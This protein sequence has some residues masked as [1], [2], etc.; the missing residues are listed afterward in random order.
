MPASASL[1]RVAAGSMVWLREGKIDDNGGGRPC[2]M[3]DALP[4]LLSFACNPGTLSPLAGR[5]DSTTMRGAISQ[6][7]RHS[8]T[9]CGSIWPARGFAAADIA[10]LGED[11]AFLKYGS[12]FPQ[13][14]TYNAGLAMLP[15]TRVRLL[16]FL[17]W[18]EAGMG[19]RPSIRFAEGG[20]APV[21]KA[22]RRATSP[23]PCTH[24]LHA[25]ADGT[26]PLRIV[27][28]SARTGEHAVQR[29]AHRDRDRP[30][31]GDCHGGRLDRRRQPVR[32][33][34]D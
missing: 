18:A 7:L 27:H 14:F 29:P 11:T 26:T 32:D 22:T 2:T 13:T 12:P 23:P 30:L 17:L 10:V 15:E 20:G 25:H 9:R 8:A 3:Q 34:E 28:V 19:W 16:L 31:C 33:G 21:G 5:G 24:T 6:L 1:H 4:V